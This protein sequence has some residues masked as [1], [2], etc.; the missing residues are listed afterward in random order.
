MAQQ[1]ISELEA[2]A[3]ANAAARK[4]L[5]LMRDI[6]RHRSEYTTLLDNLW[7]LKDRAPELLDAYEIN[8][9]GINH[10]LRLQVIQKDGEVSE[11]PASRVPAVIS[12]PDYI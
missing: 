12:R 9:I 5:D 3:Q 6:E 11:I 7:D 10:T 1:H 2:R 8:W 4:D